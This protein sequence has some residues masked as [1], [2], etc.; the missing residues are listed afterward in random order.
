M[1]TMIE[2]KCGCGRTFRPIP[3]ADKKF[4]SRKCQNTYRQR[5]IRQFKAWKA[6]RER[7]LLRMMYGTQED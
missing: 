6:K 7:R 3:S 5:E 4:F 1:S 2:C